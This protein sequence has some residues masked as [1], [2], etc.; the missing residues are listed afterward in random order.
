MNDGAYRDVSKYFLELPARCDIKSVAAHFKFWKGKDVPDSWDKFKDIA[1]FWTAKGVDVSSYNKAEIVP[2]EFWSC[3]N[4]A[5]KIQNTDA[6][7][8]A[9]VYNTIEYRNYIRLGKM[10]C[11]YDK[12]KEVIQVKSILY[13][14]S[15]IQKSMKDIERHMLHFL[16]NQDEQRLVSSEFAGPPEKGKSLMVVSATISSA[17]TMIYFG[18]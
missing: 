6:F 7:L 4:S 17:P 9:E 8:L 10:D 14:L 18:Q 16:E 5:I 1:F 15:D 13:G 11:P 3:M 12:L 2:Y